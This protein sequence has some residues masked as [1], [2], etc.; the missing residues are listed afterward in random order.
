MKKY[1]KFISKC[2]GLFLVF[3]FSS[4]I[5]ANECAEKESK[6]YKIFQ[7]GERVLLIDDEYDMWVLNRLE[8]NSRTWE[9]WWSG[10]EV[11]QPPEEYFHKPEDWLE[12]SKI[13]ISYSP[14]EKSII[15]E[16]YRNQEEKLLYCEYLIWSSRHTCAFARKIDTHDLVGWMREFLKETKF[17]CSMASSKGLLYLKQTIKFVEFW[18]E[19]VEAAENEQKGLPYDRECMDFEKRNDFL[20]YLMIL[21]EV[22]RL[23]L[24]N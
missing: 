10:I 20:A 19:V 24:Y 3:A 9:E 15:R 22:C 4:Q 18:H 13:V 6:I 8:K 21:E 12:N 23:D 5:M 17:E 11:Q 2:I 14:W 16:N 1:I 7:F